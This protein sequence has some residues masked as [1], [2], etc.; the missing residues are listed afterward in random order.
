MSPLTQN[1]KVTKRL[2]ERNTIEG[3]ENSLFLYLEGSWLLMNPSDV[4][5]SE[6][7][8]VQALGSD[9]T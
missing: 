6:I 3:K 9:A 1:N 7:H 5:N 8:L 2:Y 4:E